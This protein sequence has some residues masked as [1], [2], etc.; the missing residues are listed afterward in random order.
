[1][2][3]G[4]KRKVDE[5]GR[6]VIPM[7]IR[8]R[9]NINIGTKLNIEQETNKIIITVNKD[10]ECECGA[11]IFDNYKYCPICGREIKENIEN[12]IPRID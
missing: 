9:L 10:K 2:S 3:R 8:K 11:V 1:M 4:I 5:L 7:E 6:I 12:H